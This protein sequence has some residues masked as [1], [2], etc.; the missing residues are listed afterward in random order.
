VNHVIGSGL[1][2]ST[3][4]VSRVIVGERGSKKLDPEEL[5]PGSCSGSSFCTGILE[6]LSDGQ[7]T[8]KR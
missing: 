7:L 4:L 1:P 8:R 6:E 3:G 5:I 2:S